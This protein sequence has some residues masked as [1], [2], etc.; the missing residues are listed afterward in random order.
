MKSCRGLLKQTL[1][2][3]KRVLPISS[4]PIARW[5]KYLTSWKST[6]SES[7]RQFSVGVEGCC[8][9]FNATSTMR[10]CRF[11]KTEYPPVFL[12][13][14]KWEDIEHIQQRD[15]DSTNIA[16]FGEDTFIKNVNAS[17]PIVALENFTNRWES[18]FT[19]RFPTASRLVVGHENKGVRNEFL[20]GSPTVEAKEEQDSGHTIE[21]PEMRADKV[22]YVP[23]YGTISSLNVVTSLGIA[24]FYAYLDTYFP[25]SRT[26]IQAHRIPKEDEALLKEL[27]QYQKVFESVAPLPEGSDAPVGSGSKKDDP[28]FNPV[29]RCDPRPIH[30]MF[31]QK[32]LTTI[33]NDLTAFRSALRQL[34]GVRGNRFGLSILYENDFDQRNFGGLVR[35][36]NAFLVDH[37]F[38]IGRRKFNVVGTVGSYHYTPPIFCGP[39]FSGTHSVTSPHVRRGEDEGPLVPSTEEEWLEDVQRMIEAKCDGKVQ[40]WFLDI[41]QEKLYS[42]SDPGDNS[43]SSPA[44]LA[45][46]EEVRNDPT[47]VITCCDTEEALAAAA[48]EAPNTVLIIPQEGKLP[49]SRLLQQCS[50]V[51]QIVPSRAED[52]MRWCGLSAQV[53]SGIALQRLSSV[54]HPKIKCI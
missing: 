25:H 48:R 20:Y 11:F 33:R 46:Y 7:L 39:V 34:S 38:Y 40:F 4:N 23:Q 12:S 3:P 51:L 52:E 28:H 1:N 24:L 8:S 50:K 5:S 42:T 29:P 6:D 17:S 26:L 47:K 35:N 54:M 2:P 13:L 27:A 10:T 49:H 41:A 45:W 19:V 14:S 44:S 16:L 53:A 22:I 18:I 21:F 30:P 43:S 15:E 31:F 37:I 36:A 9:A 32:D